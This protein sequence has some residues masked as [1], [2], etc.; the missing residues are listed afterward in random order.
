MDELLKRFK[1]KAAIAKALGV[2]GPAVSRAFRRQ[3]VPATW[4]PK[5]MEQGMS[6]KV[7]TSLPLDKKAAD[8]LAALPKRG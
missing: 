4:V 2:S 6:H 1:T 8:I 5:L 7:L 3:K